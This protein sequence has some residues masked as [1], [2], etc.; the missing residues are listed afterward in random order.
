MLRKI[1]KTKEQ[2]TFWKQVENCAKQVKG[3]PKWKKQQSEVWWNNV[4]KA[5]ENQR[6]YNRTLGQQ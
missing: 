5:Q 4:K 3:W 6:E 1:K 2:K